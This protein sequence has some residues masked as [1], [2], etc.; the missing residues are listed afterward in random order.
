M[1]LTRGVLQHGTP[2]WHL[3]DFHFLAGLD[4][5]FLV[6]AKTLGFSSG[7]QESPRY[8]S[9][10]KNWIKMLVKNCIPIHSGFDGQSWKMLVHR[11]YYSQQWHAWETLL[12]PCWRGLFIWSLRSL[13]HL[14]QM[15]TVN[16]RIPPMS[17]WKCISCSP[18]QAHGTQSSCCPRE[19]R[20]CCLG[21][22]ASLLQE[23]P[24]SPGHSSGAVRRV[25]LSSFVTDLCWPWAVVHAHGC[26][27]QFEAGMSH[28]E[29][30]VAKVLER[31]K[32]NL[33]AAC[34]DPPHCPP[35]L[36]STTPGYPFLWRDSR[37][38]H[39]VPLIPK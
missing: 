10:H 36:Q 7:L 30:M 17:P 11:M 25:R 33:M 14:I 27:I 16:L 26:Q 31:R 3:Q 34:H 8:S 18:H 2:S 9:F 32:H 24:L 13:Q 19:T 37:E 22:W 20:A 28:C 29:S 38:S 12:E 15:P 39:C 4:Q 5:I 21:V 6:P 23:I 1:S 35:G